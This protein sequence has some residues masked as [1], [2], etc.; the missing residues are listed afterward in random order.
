MNEIGPPGATA[1]P[2]EPKQA[3]PVSSAPDFAPARRAPRATARDVLVQVFYHRK[4]LRGCVLFGLFAGLLGASL[5][6]TYFTAD[7]LVLVLIGSESTSAQDNSGISPTVLSID[8]LKAVQSE[9]QIID[10]DDV[11]RAAVQHVG[12]QVIYPWLR[13]PRWFGL[14]PPRNAATE[15]GL[16]VQM[17]RSEL[18]VDTDPGSSVI[19]IA[20]ANPDRATAIRVVQAVLDAYLTQRR[21][22]Y[23]STNAAFVSREI[24]RYRE[25]LAK[26]DTQIQDLRSHYGVLDMAQDAVLA[27][28]RLDGIVQRKNQVRERRVAVQTEITAVKV[29]LASQPLTV[30]DFRE[31]TNNTG[32]DEARNTL[33]RLEQQRTY[34]TSQFNPDWPGI[35]EVNKQ[36]ASARAQMGPHERNL[37]FTERQIRNPA[38]EVLNNRL[39]SLEVE[40]EA[41]GQQ[42]VELDEQYAQAED[43]VNSLRD[44]DG[45]LHGLI[46]TRDV[47][48]S[49]YRQMAQR[50]SAAVFQ[51]HVVDERNAN[52][53]VVQMA[54]APVIGRS[55][56][57]SYVA[58]GLFLGL[59]LGGAAVALATV[60]RE[61]YIMPAEAERELL[62]P[63]LAS[64]DSS[65][66]KLHVD[67]RP[68][69]ADLG[70]LLQE[71]TVDGRPLASLQII[72]TADG[73][74]KAA[75]VRA[76]AAE[77]ATGQ[78]R[79]TL[80]LDLEENGSA[81]VAALGMAPEGSV[82]K[83]SLPIEVAAT[84]T[85]R[86]W[87][88]I[89]ALQSVLV[90]RGGSVARTRR[91]LDELHQDFDVL[92]LIAPADPSDNAVRR[93]AMMVDANIMI[94]RAERTRGAVA[95]HLCDT[96]RAAGGNLLGFIFDGRKY[97]VPNWLYRWA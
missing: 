56:A 95:M 68:E 76:L 97:Y 15:E 71:V 54:T 38:L 86:L 32:N 20:F 83:R 59:L 88:G 19:R 60:L 49:V 41:L 5:A 55:M 91:I 8:G 34:L 46:V 62:L 78:E 23:A 27:T 75:I 67:D 33:V 44:A 81:Y 12:A 40:N 82:P 39:A 21:T 28:D 94:V 29:N 89:G 64:L 52:L 70:M 13:R 35:A 96:I 73:D 50:Q 58:G 53:R 22:I 42:L 9:I 4:L 47:T 24:A 63:S 16:A 18:R 26:L 2:P 69:L 92:L 3:S 61:V 93:F 87:V 48:E 14:L 6:H 72:G 45:Q 31:T 84:R 25:V 79:R 85:P 74:N 90:D 80:I 1:I 51:D 77:L 10:S 11:L 36:I 57:V 66:S 65:G 43:R 30:L 17:M 7:S 37:Y